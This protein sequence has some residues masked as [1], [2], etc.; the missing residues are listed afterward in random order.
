MPLVFAGRTGEEPITEAHER[1]R[2]IKPQ[3][4]RGDPVKVTFARNQAMA[5]MIQGMLL[6]E[7]IPSFLKRTRGFDAPEFLAGGPR[8]V[9]VPGE[10]LD[11]A[12]DVLAGAEAP[13]E[14]VE[15]E[16]EGGGG[17]PGRLAALDLAKLG[18][19]SPSP[20]PAR[21]L[22]WILAGVA[23]AALIVWLLYVAST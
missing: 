10:A 11:A 22:A 2:K 9:F 14:G 16:N 21:L 6:E 15:G 17:R 8:D 3:Y 19:E 12:R 5:E 20:S 18:D 1:A 23:L 4:A 7:G 13:D